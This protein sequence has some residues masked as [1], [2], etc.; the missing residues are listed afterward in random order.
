MTHLVIAYN[1]NDWSLPGRVTPLDE[2]PTLAQLIDGYPELIDRGRTAGLT[3]LLA[4]VT[5]HA[6]DLAGDLG[7]E[8]FRLAVNERIRTS[9]H[10]FVDFDAAIRSEAAP[11]LLED[12]YA[13][14]DHT[15]PNVNGS[16]RLAQVMAEALTRSQLQPADPSG[17]GQ[18][19]HRLMNESSCCR[20]RRSRTPCPDRARTPPR[21]PHGSG[22]RAAHPQALGY[23]PLHIRTG[24]H[25]FAV[26]ID[27]PLPEHDRQQAPYPR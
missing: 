23:F 24:G 1:S 13:A 19:D 17:R 14:P 27:D 20:H 11:S 8:D 12:K 26:L 21:S 25:R 9:G 18:Q 5:P 2:M 4:T 10:E 15:H 22:P 6:P 16:K 3:V 7:R